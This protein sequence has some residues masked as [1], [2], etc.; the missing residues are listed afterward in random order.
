MRDWSHGPV[1][2]HLRQ[3]SQDL[4]RPS[5]DQYGRVNYTSQHHHNVFLP[6]S[7]QQCPQHVQHAQQVVYSSPQHRH[8]KF[9]DTDSNNHGYDC[10]TIIH[11]PQRS[12]DGFT[13]TPPAGRAMT[14]VSLKMKSPDVR[15]TCGVPGHD[16]AS[17]SGPGG[18][19][20]IRSYSPE[21]Q[22]RT[23]L[24]QNRG[25]KYVTTLRVNCDDDGGDSLSPN[26]NDYDLHVVH[27]SKPPQNLH[28]DV[29]WTRSARVWRCGLENG[30]GCCAC[31]YM[32]AWHVLRILN[33][34]WWL[35]QIITLLCNF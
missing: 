30:R 29:A 19:Y 16:S 7:Q 14:S 12:C 34:R 22:Y 18:C 23:Y 1:Q 28:Q 32:C 4:D 3:Q 5:F 6:S 9:I 10:T 20:G 25:P 13:Q 26:A 15:D 24:S 2:I 11:R 33:K 21:M 31:V 27:P 17:F 35:W 8:R